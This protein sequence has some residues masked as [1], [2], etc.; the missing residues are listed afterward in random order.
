MSVHNFPNVSLLITH[1][2]R[3]DSLRRLLERFNSLSC[4]FGEIIVSDD[5]SK[6]DNLAKLAKL[7]DEFDFTLVT[8]TV[9]KGLG[10]NLNKGQDRVSKPYTLYVQE[11]FVP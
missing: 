3:P 5:C 2:N 4:Y 7:K 11:D 9:N 10:N 6:K 1:F 8:S